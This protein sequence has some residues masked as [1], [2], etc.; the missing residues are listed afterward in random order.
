MY[1]CRYDDDSEG[2]GAAEAE[3]DVKGCTVRR[4]GNPRDFRFE[5][6][7]KQVCCGVFL[8]IGCM[9]V[10]DECMYVLL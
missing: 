1:V 9:S 6:S 7:T 3:I 8:C 4:L 2:K 5:V 10:H